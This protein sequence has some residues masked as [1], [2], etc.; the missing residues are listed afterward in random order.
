MLI[1]SY[2]TSGTEQLLLYMLD[3]PNISNVN[4]IAE[5]LYNMN[6]HAFSQI[7]YLSKGL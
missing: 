7:V 1:C 4:E 3:H 6:A 5:T 2:T